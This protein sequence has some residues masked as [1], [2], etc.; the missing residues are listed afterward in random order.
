MRSRV[1]IL[2]QWKYSIQELKRRRSR[3]MSYSSGQRCSTMN[4]FTVDGKGRDQPGASED[5][6]KRSTSNGE[7]QMK[8]KHRNMCW[9]LVRRSCRCYK[10]RMLHSK[11]SN[12]TI[13]RGSWVLQERW[14]TL[15]TLDA[16]RTG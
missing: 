12:Q 11:P 4:C 2:L 14:T 16:A 8:T 1:H 10:R 13:H 15:P 9:I 7:M 3:K 5:R 6:T